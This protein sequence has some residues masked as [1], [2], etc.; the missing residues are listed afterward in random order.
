MDFGNGRSYRWISFTL[1]WRVDVQ[2][3]A[4]FAL[5]SQIGQKTFQVLESSFRHAFQRRWL[6]ADVCNS[7][8]NC[9]RWIKNL[10]SKFGGSKSWNGFYFFLG[11]CVGVRNFTF[12][13]LFPTFGYIFSF[14]QI[15]STN[16]NELCGESLKEVNKK[17][18]GFKMSKLC[19][20]D[21]FFYIVKLEF[22]VW[23]FATCIQLLARFFHSGNFCQ[24]ISINYME[25]A[26]KKKIRN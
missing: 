22:R 26:L 17:L 15:L 4:I 24:R 20:N 7:S 11:M 19:S 14:R 8:K 1:S 5:V 2:I 21:F 16:F 23:T 3:Q 10:L 18:A 6:V 9:S 25:K 12:C 13:T